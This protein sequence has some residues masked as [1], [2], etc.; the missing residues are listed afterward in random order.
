MAATAKPSTSFKELSNVNKTIYY[1]SMVS[2]L[3]DDMGL[4]IQ[5]F[6][7]NPLSMKFY[8]DTGYC[9]IKRKTYNLK[10]LYDTFAE[11]CNL[12]A[13]GVKNL[14]IKEIGKNLSWFIRASAASL[15][16]QE[17]HV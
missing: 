11:Y 9:V 12:D 17:Y 3:P 2:Y 13:G 4:D 8:I 5:V 6:E 16:M 15:G 14:L 1:K 10:C 7:N